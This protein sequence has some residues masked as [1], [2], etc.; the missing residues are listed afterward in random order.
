MKIARYTLYFICLLGILPGAVFAQPYTFPTAP[1]GSEVT[2]TKTG[3]IWRR[4]AEGMTWNGGT[5]AGTPLTFT[6]EAALQR[7]AAQASS[8]GVA[9]RL[10]N[11]KE[12]SS[13]VD[14]SLTNPSI[15]RTAFP[16]TPSKLFWS[17]TPYVSAPSSAQVTDFNS[18]SSGGTINPRN[19]PILTNYLR[20]VRG[21][22]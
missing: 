14:R 7:A 17:S 22:F 3:L 1:D 16:A 11:I 12:L 10:P 4:C 8:T 5:C 21:G 2:D 13:I 9:W 18:G 15:D 19:D 6:H 20:L